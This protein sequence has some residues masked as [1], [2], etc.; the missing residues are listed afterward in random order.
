MFW[1]FFELYNQPFSVFI[2]Y[3]TLVPSY[4]NGEEVV[5]KRIFSWGNKQKIT[6]RLN[7]IA[8]TNLFFIDCINDLYKKFN[9]TLTEIFEECFPLCYSR[10]EK[11]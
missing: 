1:N 8:W 5:S 11:Y 10:K 7:S 9:D 3:E 6:E 2:T 4:C